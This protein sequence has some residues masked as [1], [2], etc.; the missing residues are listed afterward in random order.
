MDADGFMEWF[1][2]NVLLLWEMHQQRYWVT[3][4]RYGRPAIAHNMFC[5][6]WGP[7]WEGTEGSPGSHGRAVPLNEFADFDAIRDCKKCG[8]V[9]AFLESRGK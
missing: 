2:K 6:Y 5:A 9:K 3:G 8:G 1:G 4:G 7:T